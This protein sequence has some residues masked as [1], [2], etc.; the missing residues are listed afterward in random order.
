MKKL[1]MEIW[2]ENDGSLGMLIKEWDET[3][4]TTGK[5]LQELI[6]NL[7]DAL[8]ISKINPHI[9]NLLFFKKENAC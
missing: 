4:I 3:L 5:N 6:K 8:S 7:K 9:I 1:K 2:E